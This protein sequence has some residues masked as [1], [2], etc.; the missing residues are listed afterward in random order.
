ML[1]RI[2]LFAGLVGIVGLTGCFSL[3]QDENSR[4]IDH[5][6]KS[7]DEIRKMTNKYFMDYDQDDPFED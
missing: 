3:N 4:Q 5:Y 7:F 6:G 2:V 1:R